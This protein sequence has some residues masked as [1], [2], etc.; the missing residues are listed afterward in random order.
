MATAKRKTTRRK[1][2]EVSP[3]S[4]PERKEVSILRAKNGYTVNVSGVKRDQYYSETYIAKTKK[5]ASD[6]A[7]KKLR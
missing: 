6:L 1:V 5:E 4:M 7:S 2:N 3:V